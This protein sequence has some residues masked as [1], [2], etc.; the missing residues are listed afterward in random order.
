M[1]LP[2]RRIEAEISMDEHT[3]RLEATVNHI[4]S[5]VTEMKGDIRR[6]DAKV[7]TVRSEFSAKFDSLNTKVDSHRDESQKSF[8]T[9][10]IEIRNV[11]LRVQKDLH[12]LQRWMYGTIAAIAVMLARSFGLL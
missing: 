7:E 10:G 5:D 12:T 11:E 6:L 4:Q 9:L 8:A 2:T 1:A 3:A